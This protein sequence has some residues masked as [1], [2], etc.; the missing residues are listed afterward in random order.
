MTNGKSIIMNKNV[1]IHIMMQD[2]VNKQ[3]MMQDKVYTHSSEY[4]GIRQGKAFFY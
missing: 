2:E 4:T 1:M 3:S